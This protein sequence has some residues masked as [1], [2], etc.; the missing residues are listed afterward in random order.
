VLQV[1]G[2]PLASPS[3][4]DVNPV[5][6]EPT[7]PSPPAPAPKSSQ[8]SVGPTAEPRPVRSGEPSTA[9]SAEPAPAASGTGAG[10]GP[11]GDGTAGDS[12][13]SAAPEPAPNG[14]PGP[15]G[16]GA[17]PTVDAAARGT[18]P[19]PSDEPGLLEGHPDE[20]ATTSLLL[21]LGVVVSVAAVALLGTGWMLAS[22]VRDD[23]PEAAP[24]D[25]GGRLA[26]RNPSATSIEERRARRRARRL[27]GHD[28]VL[29]AMGLDPDAP[30]EP[31]RGVARGASPRSRSDGRR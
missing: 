12:G 2:V 10:G 15:G 5:P 27:P 23:E 26:G 22:R 31:T 9:A 1:A 20:P 24:G 30:P 17:A 18:Q 13:S 14:S 21:L 19:P 7:I 11:S 6:S 16:G 28:P 25:A 3:G 8:A 4:P 29:A